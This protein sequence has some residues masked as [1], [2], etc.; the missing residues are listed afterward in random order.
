LAEDM[1]AALALHQEGRLDEAIALYE[2]LMAAGDRSADLPYLL[3]TAYCET[4]AFEA[5]VGHL[6]KALAIDGAYA[7]AA[8]NLG[9]ALN[10]IGRHAEAL[11]AF[12]LAVSLDAEPAMAQLNRGIALQHLERLREAVEAFGEAIR[13]EPGS[14]MARHR[15]GAAH[16]A[17][18]E[19]ERAIE[20]Y[21]AAI[22]IAPDF[23][24]A[25]HNLAI[26]RQERGEHAAALAHCEAALAAD[27]DNAGVCD[28]MGMALL[29]LGRFD[30]AVEAHARAAA[31]A[32]K[33]AE[34]HCNRAFSLS[35]ARRF[36]EAI[37]E[38]DIALAQKPELHLAAVN[39][40]IALLTTGRYAQGWP[41][42]EARFLTDP[43]VM[44]GGLPEAR[45]WR[46]QPLAWRTI[47]LHSEQGLG[48]TLQF[49][50]YAPLLK[51][52]GARVLLLVERP[53]VRLMRAAP[54]VDAVIDKAVLNIPPFDWHAPLMSLPLALGTTMETIP[55]EAPYLDVD[56]ARVP[57]WRDRIGPAGLRIGVCWKANVANPDIARSFPLEAL[58]PLS[59]I[60]GVRLISVYKG[61][62]EDEP[63]S[64]PGGVAVEMLGEDYNAGPDGFVDTAA[65]MKA[66]DL[67]ISADTASAH[68]A[69]ALGVPAWIALKAVPDW[70]WFM[71]RGDSPW[72][73]S[74]RLFRQA[75]PGDWNG[76]F[77]EMARAISAGLGRG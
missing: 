28:V 66:L 64:R 65:A 63:L 8:L 67:V 60:P 35:M 12:D 43:E 17:L 44:V 58:A 71:G 74:L 23:A 55:G 42:F 15:R 24:A 51:A 54:G 14:A 73:P 5:G 68:L 20:D 16:V 61:A 27:P 45:R 3:G 7:P 69:G 31:L 47:L 32:P 77:A 62:G 22:A 29:A 37:A 41:L 70:R 56:P 13:L 25:R 46:G 18:G 6:M 76:V 38:C 59:R 2:R 34:F 53:L 52:M 19:K 21:G 11:E 39:K 75:S 9:A 10:E 57:S 72:Y 4:G 33:V 40:A 30:E 1:Q 48:D 49:C 26:L 50:R 36:D